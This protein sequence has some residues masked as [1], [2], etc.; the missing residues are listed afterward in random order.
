M[1][2]S[3]KGTQVASC[4]IRHGGKNV[5]A[6]YGSNWIVC[7]VCT[8]GPTR[9]LKNSYTVK[10]RAVDRSNIQFWTQYIFLLHKKSENPWM[11]F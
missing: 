10:S 4:H 11:C 1:S 9:F 2:Q 8:M 6:F 3:I 7:R 5:Q